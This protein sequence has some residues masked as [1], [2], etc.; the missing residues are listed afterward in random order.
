MKKGMIFLLSLAC[1]GT[2]C[3][4]EDI[5]SWENASSQ[6]NGNGTSYSTDPVATV[7][8]DEDDDVAETSF[9]RTISIVF[10]PSGAASVSGDDK[11]VV[12]VNGNQVTVNNTT[13][14]EKVKYQLSGSTANGYFKVYS[15]NKQAIILNGVSI[16]N[17]NGAA[18]NNQGKK[19]CFVIVNGTNSLAD[20]ASYTATPAEEDEKA[21]FFSEGQLIFS[22]QGTLSVTANGKSGISSDDYLHFQDAPTITVTSAAGH[23]FRGKD[24]IQV[25]GGT[26][27]ATV[28]G[29][30]K[31]GMSSDS[32][33]VFNGGVTTLNVSGGV[34]LE[35]GEYTGSA[36]VRADQLFVMNDGTLTVTNSGQGGKGISCDGNG[37]FQGGTVKVTVT[38]S[39]YGQSS[40]G[41]RPGWG[42]GSSSSD[43]SKSA[44]G[45][46]CEGNIFISGGSIICTVSS[47]EGLES[48]GNLVISGGETHVT[49]TGDDAINSAY[50]MDVTGGFVYANSSANDAMDANHDMKLSGGYVF[51]VCTKGTPEVALDANT[52][53]RY[54]LYINSGATV[55]AYGGLESGYSAS[56]SVYG[57]SCKAGSWNA[58]YDGST[59]I[60][61]FKAPSGISSVAV[62][63]PSLSKGYTGV[64]VGS[65]LCN[66]V[67]A[68]GGISG[69]D[70]VTLSTYSGGSQGGGPGGGG[71]G[72]GWPR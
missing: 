69:G 21:A 38:G 59:F 46:K 12:S 60:A 70:A 34:L 7:E 71:P 29:D 4:K 19:R 65:E 63:S 44:K 39:N 31:K 66:G 58:L 33:V 15:N 25:S 41:G 9:D 61:A 48:K 36:G 30:G 43:S 54:T 42:G 20:G 2:A 62:S 10:S 51:A 32:L 47:H 24:Y 52:E 14:E 72:G 13:T 53:E 6:E 68:S 11:G 22:G 64:S 26:L 3:S 49:S 35:D 5:F 8:E 1:L 50:E 57:M 16:T 56:Q 27:K 23:G 45:I 17:P 55:V 67:W 40:S 28:S 18:I 37:Y